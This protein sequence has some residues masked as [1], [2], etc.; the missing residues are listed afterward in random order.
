M[1]IPGAGIT[2]PSIVDSIT[3]PLLA[4]VYVF[5]HGSISIAGKTNHS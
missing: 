3:V 5:D 2:G 1:K 4:A